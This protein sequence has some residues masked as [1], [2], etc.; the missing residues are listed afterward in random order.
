[1]T[2]DRILDISSDTSMKSLTKQKDM[3]SKTCQ[4]HATA[5]SVCYCKNLA[6]Y[7][8]PHCSVPYCLQHGL[9]HQEELKGDL[10]SLLAKAQ[11]KFICNN[12]K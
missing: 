12:T 2:T 7:I 6:T 1:M 11:V 8:C 10:R 9:Q 3:N 5:S 4:Y